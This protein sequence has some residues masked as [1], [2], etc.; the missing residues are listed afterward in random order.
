MPHFGL[1]DSDALGP[2]EAPLMRARLH[3][4]AGKRRLKQGKI[5]AGI[6][7]LYD[8]LISAMDWYVAVPERKERL[9]LK[10]D[11]NLHHEQT[12][13]HVL[14]RSGIIG[15]SFDFESLERIVEKALESDQPEH[16]KDFDYHDIQKEIEFIL[17]QLG[18]MPFDE[19]SL[20]QEDPATF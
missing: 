5:S 11:E 7:T 3:M 8:A 2:V 6:V 14:Q 10:K 13:V 20:P 1:M 17:H 16:M 4:R 18:V 9:N 12:R 19:N 15:Q